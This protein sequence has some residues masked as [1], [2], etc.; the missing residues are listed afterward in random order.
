MGSGPRVLESVVANDA[1][2]LLVK[3]VCSPVA[4]ARCDDGC[5]GELFAEHFRLVGGGRMAEYGD[6]V[7]GFAELAFVE[8][9][10]EPC[11]EGRLARASGEVAPDNDQARMR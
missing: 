8:V 11:G 2:G 4:V 7:A 1:T 5:E 3:P 6:C 10:G 9:C